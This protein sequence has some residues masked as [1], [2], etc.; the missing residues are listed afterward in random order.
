M[1]REGAVGVVVVVIGVVVVVVGIVVF[2]GA[3]VLVGAAVAEAMGRWTLV[4]GVGRQNPV[5]LPWW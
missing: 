1:K 2:V 4:F 3:V 5:A